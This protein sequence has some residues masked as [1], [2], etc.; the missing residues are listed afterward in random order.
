M[1]LDQKFVISMYNK[2]ILHILH[3]KK[4]FYELDNDPKLTLKIILILFYC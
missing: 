1:S 4:K 2:L 3:K